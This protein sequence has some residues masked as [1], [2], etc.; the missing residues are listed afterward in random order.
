MDL[1]GQDSSPTSVAISII[2]HSRTESIVIDSSRHGR[3]ILP[4]YTPP[5]GWRRLFY[6]PPT[7]LI[8][9]LS[10]DDIYVIRREVLHDPQGNLIA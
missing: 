6:P 9:T 5:K 4:P 7:A 10:N 8:L 3:R 2:N 1:I